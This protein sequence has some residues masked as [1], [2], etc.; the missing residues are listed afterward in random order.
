MLQ[1]KAGADAHSIALLLA[2]IGGDGAFQNWQGSKF[3]LTQESSC[4]LLLARYVYRAQQ[5]SGMI[6]D[7][8]WHDRRT[9]SSVP[10][11]YHPFRI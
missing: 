7:G 8:R 5:I 6:C 11:R 1:L 10:D 4:S 2:L 9:K 3:K